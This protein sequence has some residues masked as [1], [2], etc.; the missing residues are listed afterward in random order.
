MRAL[1]FLGGGEIFAK[2]KE[3]HFASNVPNFIGFGLSL[4]LV[5]FL[6]VILNFIGCV[7]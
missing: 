7:K 4:N 5:E 3:I 2:I 6:K 1:T